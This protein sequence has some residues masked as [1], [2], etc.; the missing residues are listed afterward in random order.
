MKKSDYSVDQILSIR[1]TCLES[2]V[3]VG[4]NTVHLLCAWFNIKQQFFWLDDTVKAIAE[5]TGID[6]AP[7][8]NGSKSEL[9]IRGKIKPELAKS[10]LYKF[11]MHYNSNLRQ[12]PLENAKGFTRIICLV[13]GIGSEF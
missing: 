7:D 5:I 6:I 13:S 11:E 2:G 10:Y 3:T 1:K 9:I 12:G 4:P 8:D